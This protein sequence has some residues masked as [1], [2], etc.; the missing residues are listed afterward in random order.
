MAE[1]EYGKF[2]QTFDFKGIDL[3]TASDRPRGNNALILKNV[4]RGKEGTVVP[5][6]GLNQVSAGLA[7]TSPWWNTRRLNDAATGANLLIHSIGSILATSD[8]AGAAL[9]SRDTGYSGAPLT[10]VPFVPE[11]TTGQWMAVADATKMRKVNTSGTV[12][13]L[14]LAT[15]LAPPE[16]A[17]F[18][19][20]DSL[21][22]EVHRSDIHLF[23]ATG[24]T[25]S[26]GINPATEVLTARVNTTVTAYASWVYGGASSA[27]WYS[28]RLANMSGIGRGTLIRFGAG[29][30]RFVVSE[31]YRESRATAVAAVDWDSL[32][33]AVVHTSANLEEA[34]QGALVQIG[35]THYVIHA[36]YTNPDGI[37]SLRVWNPGATIAVLDAVQVRNSMFGYLLGA[38][39]VGGLAVAATATNDGTSWGTAGNPLTGQS[40]YTITQA[41]GADLTVYNSGTARVSV[42]EVNDLCHIS[43]Y[44]SDWDDVA[45]IKLQLDLD[46]GTFL[47]NYLSRSIRPSDLT[48]I[49]ADRNSA[50]DARVVEARNERLDRLREFTREGERAGALGPFTI[51]MG[52]EEIAR[53]NEYW[54]DRRDFV[55]PPGSTSSQTGTGR[56][57]W[58]EI[59]FRLSDFTKFGTDDTKT[60]KLVNS[61][62]IVIVPKSSTTDIAT[63]AFDAWYITGGYQPDVNGNAPYEYRYRVR[64]SQTGARS[65]WSPPGRS[66]MF[67]SRQRVLVRIPAVSAAFG[68]DTIDV[69]RRG[70]TLN[71]W[72]TIGSMA[73]GGVAASFTDNISDNVALGF[74]AA[75]SGVEGNVNTE[76]FTVQTAALS[77]NGTIVGTLLEDAGQFDLSL[78][79][80]TEI[81]VD[82]IPTKIYQVHT[83]NLVELYDSCMGTGAGVWSI[84][85]PYKTGQP[86]PVVFGDLDGWYF[87][88]GNSN[89]PGELYFF[90]QYTMDSTRGAYHVPVTSGDDPLMNGCVY[91]GRA[92]VWS[93]SKL[94]TLSQDPDH[95][96]RADPIPVPDGLYA[97]YALAVGDLIYWLGRDGIYAFDGATVTSVSD[98]YLRPLFRRSGVPGVTTHGVN[99]VNT[100]DTLTAAQRNLFRLAICGQYLMFTY[101]PDG[102]ATDVLVLDRWDG[103][104]SDWGWWQDD[105]AN[106]DVR[107][108]YEEEGNGVHR[109]LVGGSQ[110]Q[111]ELYSLGGSG[112]TD[113]GTAFTCQVRLFALDGGDRRTEKLIGDATLEL[114]PGT[115]SI[116]PTWWFDDYASSVV[117]TVIS[118]TG[119]GPSRIQDFDGGRYARNIALDLAWS[120]SSDTFVPEIF[121]WG[122]TVMGRPSETIKRAT[123][124]SDLG[125]WG[126]KELRGLDIECDTEGNSKTV[127]VEY[128]KEDGTVGS[129]SFTVVAAQKTIVPLALT[130]P[131]V[132]Y[133][134][135]LRPT[136]ALTWRLYGVAQWHFDPLPDINRLITEWDNFD[137]LRYVHGVEVEGDTNNALVNIVAQKE[138]NVTG[139][140]F[141][142]QHNGR[143]TRSYSFNP[144]FLAYQARLVP[145]GNARIMR[146]R[147]LTNPEAP[148]G[149][150]WETQEWEMGDPYGFSREFEIEYASTV[151]VTLK[152]Y[153][154][155][156]LVHT[157]ATTLVSTG[158]TETWRRKTVDL[159]AVKGRLARIRLEHASTQF[160]A[161]EKGSIVRGK[162][163]GGQQYG[164]MPV[165]GGPHRDTGA[166]V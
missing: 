88:L 86:M 39:G 6:P 97:R 162:Q 22:Q 144:P 118:G 48:A 132:G 107:F 41:L 112:K 72:V 16:A 133:E 59:W 7:A 138:F 136:D 40:I 54:N 124:Y 9:T 119:S 13:K 5:R 66:G 137:G 82:G 83:T 38:T 128:T 158:G 30:G 151:T 45:E 135:R 155:G 21:G 93:S 79:Q 140:D 108:F 105:Y 142:M 28:V 101:T 125:H 61:V 65:N 36:V 153:V 53:R 8:T 157:D 43:A 122:F 32:G 11:Q 4:R 106:T 164:T 115:A 99:A 71:E 96:W 77:G 131:V 25:E 95:I 147:W 15:P 27:G 145:G 33:W 161:R 156:V 126:P 84:P 14:G 35:A 81:L 31:I 98:E 73:N 113:D 90:N 92:Y 85:K 159:P 62:R 134:F 49:A 154:D 163:F 120:M 160:R 104:A 70:G 52:D 37:K 2:E 60:L 100:V 89:T 103:D 26:A 56:D 116:T 1:N 117:G 55:D 102:T 63:V 67:A 91:N 130:S 94:F 68:A 111:S 143:G 44:C 141:N 148:L 51:D 149:H 42:D 152:Y 24:W 139:G 10:F 64:D 69:Q 121:G 87:A 150:V 50:L 166:P 18:E 146:R 110:A 46:D 3:N 114:E 127:L 165:V 17:F 75:T 129:V 12:R 123:D 47:K 80:G 58:S 19:E 34:R 76:P 78:A 57:Q 109:I 74:A 23:D 20:N 29:S